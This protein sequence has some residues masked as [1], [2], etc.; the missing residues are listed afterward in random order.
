MKYQFLLD[1]Y[2]PPYNINSNYGFLHVY[3]L[4]M[5]LGII[6]SIIACFLK[7][8]KYELPMDTLILSVIFIIPSALLFASFFGKVTFNEFD[9][10]SFFVY[11]AFWQA[12]MSIHGG[13]LGGV[14]AAVLYFIYPSRKYKIS[15]WVWLDCIV[16]NILIGQ[17]IGRWGNFF[18]HELLGM[19]TSLEH[20]SW[21]PNWI[22]YNCWQWADPNNHALGPEGYPNI[23]YRQPIFLY[24]SILDTFAWL[25]I[26]FIIPNLGKWFGPKPWKKYPK[27]YM[28]SNKYSFKKIFNKKLKSNKFKTRKEIWNIV[29]FE[30]KISKSEIENLE[31]INKKINFKK[32]NKSYSSKLLKLNNPDNYWIIRCGVQGGAYFF[33][34]NIIR[35]ILET[36]RTDDI[37]FIHN[38]RTLDYTIISIIALIGILLIILAQWITPHYQRKIGWLYEKEY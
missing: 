3:A 27:E 11:F 7:S 31:K 23:I 22:K 33:F 29:Y 8:K 38:M 21:L 32:Y 15:L 17:A 35:L 14:I 34:W 16:P 2:N 1:D 36:Q 19:P 24:E 20:L 18:N 6:F 30:Y 10:N 25:F 37:L 26:T 13:V 9:W 28:I 4:T 12:G 5:T